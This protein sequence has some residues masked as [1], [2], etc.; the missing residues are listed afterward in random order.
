MGSRLFEEIREKR[1]LCYSVSAASHAF[2]DVAD[3]AAQLGP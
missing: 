1:G 2:S 3:P